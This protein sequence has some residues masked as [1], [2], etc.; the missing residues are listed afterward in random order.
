MKKIISLLVCSVCCGLATAQQTYTLDQLKQLAVE[1]NYILRSARNAIQQSKETKSEAFTKYFPA[2]SATG[3]GVSFNK[4]LI[5]VDLGLP[6]ELSS[7]LAESEVP[8]SVKMIKHGVYG[9][10]SAIQPVFM[11]GQII[12]GNKLAKVGVE[13]GEIKLEASEDQIEMLT[14]QYY[15][16]IV[17]FKEKL[18][19]LNSIHQLL[20]ELEKEVDHRVRAG[21]INRNDL[22]QVQL[23]K[24][25]VES[26]QLEAENMMTTI[27]E[28]LAQH[29]G[30]TD[31]RIDVSVPAELDN[32][33]TANVPVIPAGLRQEHQ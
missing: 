20:V 27:S 1:N 5:D 28:L 12:N 7:L 8:T 4:H 25:E 24:G 19:T 23:R 2:L 10:V 26:M 31:E 18:K 9:S 11:G 22:L 16:Q 32:M 15:W 21:V 29:I 13:T 30:K 14:E 17:S 3:V 6:A 33:G